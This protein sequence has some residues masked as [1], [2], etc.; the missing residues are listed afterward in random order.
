MPK[1]A[2]APRATLPDVPP[3]G[4]TAGVDWA[5]TDHA[6]AVVNAKGTRVEQ[7]A[8]DATGAGLCELVRRLRRGKVAEVAIER[9]DGLVVD[10][11]LAAGLTV[12]VIAPNQLNNLRGRYG[13]AGN[14]DDRFDAF[15]LAPT[16]TCRPSSGQV[17][18]Y[19]S[20]RLALGMITETAPDPP[21]T[22]S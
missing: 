16:A 18:N 7:F 5:T 21:L 11:L 9:C 10:T 20:Q 22:R 3:G 19:V 14:K 13:T 2:T 1:P 15:V 8:V 17:I 12:V 6:V 4:V